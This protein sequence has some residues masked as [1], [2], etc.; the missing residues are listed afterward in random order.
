MQGT[1]D[2]GPAGE[3]AG[4]QDPARGP[5]GP[6]PAQDGVRR[7]GNRAVRA[8]N[9]RAHDPATA[10]GGPADGD[11][12]HR[13]GDGA[14][15]ARGDQTRLPGDGAARVPDDQARRPGHPVAQPH[16]DHGP[17]RYGPPAPDPG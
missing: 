16:E 6:A 13:S 11:S 3:P 10:Q 9:E 5:E 15:R 2:T 17:V 8:Q 14:S 1:E 4:G 7:P 12:A